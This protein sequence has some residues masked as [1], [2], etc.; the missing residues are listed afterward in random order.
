MMKSHN[1]QH[2]D[3]SL[4]ALF[5]HFSFWF[6]L[7]F[8]TP[9]F[10]AF[11]NREDIVFSIAVLAGGAGFACIAM[12]LISRK[13]FSLGGQRIDKWATR[14]LLS[15]AIMLAIQ[16]N[17]IHDLFYYGAFNGERVDFRAYGWMFWVEWLG[18]LA[19]FPLL[20]W[21][22]ARLPRLPTWLPALPVLSFIMLLS[23]V[24]L[25]PADERSATASVS[26]I[27]DS[28]F[29][30][31][32]VRN[33]IHLLPDGFQ[34]D[35]V[36]QVFEEHPELATKFE[37]F[38]LFTDHV[39]MH[40]GTAPALY[41]IL[42]GKPFELD[43]GFS[44]ERVTPDI[45][46]NSYQ[47]ELA[48]RGYQVDYV[49]ISGFICIEDAVSCHVRPFNDMKSR[50]YF[51]HRGEH[52]FYSVRLILDLA[53][54]RL[55][56]MFLKEK[57]Y[58]QGHWFFADT[59]LDGSSPWPDPVI[60]EWTENLHVI[61]DRPVY[62]W[63]HYVGTHIPAKWD[64]AC[65]L[66]PDVGEDREHYLAQTYC[67]LIGVA[68][69][70]DRLKEAGI[71]DQTA[72]L[73]SGDHG[74]NIPPADLASPPLNAG[75]IKNLMGSGRPALLA[76]RLNNREPLQFSNARARLLDVA[77]TALALVE[78]E[79]PAPSA[80][81]I[82]DDL[83]RDRFFR[84]YSMADFWTGNPIPYVEYNVG[85]PANEGSQWK[86]TKIEDFGKTPTVFD[87]VNRPNAKGYV[88]GAHL[89]K[90]PGNDKSSW[91]IGRQ[92][93]FVIGLPGPARERTLDLKM[94]IPEWMPGQSFTAEVNGGS[95]WQSPPLNHDPDKHW[96]IFSIPLPADVQLVGRNFVS[97]VFRNVYHPPDTDSWAGSA[98]VESIKVTDID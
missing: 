96:Q 88:M 47:N 66:L 97:I 48:A 90:S 64:A 77:P 59:T 4:A 56:P 87:P 32:S 72:I 15:A 86:V 70:L 13:A 69:L 80:F 65:T 21:L 29:A 95:P 40:H 71:Y 55:T 62:K 92:L 10:I 33:L 7:L 35:V 43:K 61:N 67:I 2:E 6:G 75:L 24:I 57:I 9:L 52:A 36:K 54:F 42:T 89:R 63:Y 18:W 27:D 93:A 81:E 23:P 83:Q 17:V 5:S 20:L 41:T 11:H 39:G 1:H 79:S 44:Y 16:G 85:Q 82:P 58:N 8:A 25:Q 51:R 50:G 3:S 12:T 84:R 68:G 19:A 53:L 78:V 46:A 31:S 30:F 14:F 22:L 26:E 98:L 94:H 76:K 34:S 45:Q 38:T 74:V 60:R 37:G 91:V 73:I 49:P 28:V